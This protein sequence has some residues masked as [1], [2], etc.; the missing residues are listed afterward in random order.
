MV[1]DMTMLVSFSWKET[2]NIPDWQMVGEIE[3]K[4][5][6]IVYMTY[7]YI[8]NMPKNIDRDFKKRVRSTYIHFPL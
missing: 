5:S 1:S 6:A 4:K 2:E 3:K 8:Q 7:S